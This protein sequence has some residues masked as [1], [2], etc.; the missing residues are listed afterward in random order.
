MSYVEAADKLLKLE[1]V[2]FSTVMNHSCLRYKT[3]FF[4]MMFKRW[5]CLVIK[6]SAD[7]VN[8]LID[9]GIGKPFDITGKKF[10]EWIMIPLDFESDFESYMT[11][12]LEF[13]ESEKR[14]G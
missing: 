8:E 10:R 4:A 1:G 6:L 3:D 11:E 2:Q 7:R 12:A 5:D 9:T 13:A 14:R